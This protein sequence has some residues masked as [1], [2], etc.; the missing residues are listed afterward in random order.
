[1]HRRSFLAAAA[2]ATIAAP[3]LARRAVAQAAPVIRLV[4]GDLDEPWGIAF[5]PGGG[6]LVTD[7]GGSLLRLGADGS[8]AAVSGA[9]P[10]EVAGQGGLLD[11]MVPRDFARSRAVF[12]TF[13]K[14]QGNGAGTA[15]AAAR[16]ASD[17]RSLTDLRVI[18][19]AAPGGRGGRHFGSRV[20]ELPDGTLAMTIGDRGNDALAQDLSRHEGTVVRLNRDGSVPADNP[21]VGRKD[22]RPEIWSWGHRNPQG[23]AL[24]ARGRLWVSEHGP[25]GG[26]EVNL[27]RR[28][29]NYGWPKVTHGTAYSGLPI[30]N[31]RSAPGYEDPAHVWVPSI[32]PSGH[33]ICSGRMF[34]DWRGHHLIG[35]L[36]FNLIARLD[37]TTPG[38]AGWAET[39]IETP[40][41]RRVR[42]VR[43]AP[44]GAIW[45]IAENAGAIFRMAAPGA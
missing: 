24:D 25:R 41:T 1:M 27:V 44:D 32:A 15:L 43:E 21:F 39:R 7:R 22:A 14:R 30:T 6:A 17:G 40:E 29:A 45:F 18:F 3:A 35:S 42:D 16:L 38:P 5:V 31:L 28:G 36:K 11:V 10:V 8:R 26:D 13:S 23:A 12:L 2:A 33:A 37:P 20:V 19:E 34:P 9:P 4:A